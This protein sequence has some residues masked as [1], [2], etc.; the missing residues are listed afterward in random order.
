MLVKKHPTDNENKYKGLD[1]ELLKSDNIPWEVVY[2]NEILKNNGHLENKTYITYNSTALLNT[3]ILFK[4]LGSSNRFITL[5]KLLNTP[6][7]KSQTKPL[8]DKYF[9]KFK[10]FYEDYYYELESIEE[11]FSFL[12]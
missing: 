6:A 10:T 7:E 3:R 8:L 12:H 1:L 4:D 11:L 2:L 9:E 5:N